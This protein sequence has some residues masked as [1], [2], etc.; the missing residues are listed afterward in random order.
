MKQTHVM[1]ASERPDSLP[2]SRRLECPRCGHEL[3]GSAQA[4]EARGEEEGVCSEC[5]L[6][7]DWS[8]LREDAYAPRW[9]VEARI[10]R[11]SLLR[12]TIATLL[13]CARP[14]RFWSSI[15]LAL[16]ISRRGII[17][18]A[19]MVAAILHFAGVMRRVADGWSSY[20]SAI[21]ANT[22][23]G[24]ESVI[25]DVVLISITPLSRF[26][27]SWIFH[28]IQAND[29][30]RSDVAIV[31]KTAREFVRVAAHPSGEELFIE[32]SSSATSSMPSYAWINAQL[33]PLL[34]GEA[35]ATTIAAITLPP[36]A[37]FALLLIPTSLRRARIQPRHF[38]RISMYSCALWVPIFTLALMLPFRP[39]DYDF[40][41]IQLFNTPH[42]FD[43]N[44]LNP[45][46]VL[47]TASGVLT[48]LWMTAAARNYLRLPHALGIGIATTLVTLLGLMLVRSL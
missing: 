12:R 26:D 42:I 29:R 25:A 2:R 14:F 35:P 3:E 16:P 22:S 47:L 18:F 23:L 36:L 15:E 39:V 43:P 38:V 44:S 30:T 34:D 13:M 28:A 24:I 31:L 27:G 40:F 37:P 6:T 9:F 41:S 4:A 11:W 17:A 19:V 46:M 48:A 1:I 33:V 10:A 45:H 21:Q 5:G 7:V 8:K 32:V 20:V